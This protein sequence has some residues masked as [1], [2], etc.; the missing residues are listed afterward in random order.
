MNYQYKAYLYIFLIFVIGIFLA[1]WNIQKFDFAQIIGNGIGFSLISIGLGYFI[2]LAAKA[3]RIWDYAD[4]SETALL[5]APQEPEA[6]QNARRKIEYIINVL[7]YSL[8]AAIILLVIN[9]FT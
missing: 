4:A 7:K 8:G 9:L 2:N 3:L 1:Y 5:D 6:L